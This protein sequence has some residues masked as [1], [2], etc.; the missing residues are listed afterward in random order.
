MEIIRRK[1]P[2]NKKTRREKTNAF[3]TR[4]NAKKIQPAKTKR[5]IFAP[6]RPNNRSRDEIAEID[7][8]LPQRTNQLGGGHQPIQTDD[9]K[10]EDKEPKVP[11]EGESQAD[12]K[13]SRMT[14]L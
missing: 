8:N 11:E 12:Q 5:T 4:E 9:E 1:T 3:Q 2:K 13:T 7:A 6:S 10:D 14:V